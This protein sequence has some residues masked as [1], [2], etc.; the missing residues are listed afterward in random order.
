VPTHR[1]DAIARQRVSAPS[2]NK[3][4]LLKCCL[5]SVALVLQA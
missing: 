1:P 5:I 4:A 3:L 2:R